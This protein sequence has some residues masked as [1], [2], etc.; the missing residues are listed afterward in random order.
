MIKFVY[1]C[2]LTKMFS[3][4]PSH[5]RIYFMKLVTNHI[6]SNPHACKL[7]FEPLSKHVMYIVLDKIKN[8]EIM[9]NRLLI[10][11]LRFVIFN[12][13][14]LE[15][16]ILFFIICLMGIILNHFYLIIVIVYPLF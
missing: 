16:F 11:Y 13:L 14:D 12:H 1:L 5:P 6:F 2:F 4:T 10:E 3:F 15:I 8:V 9:L 7:H